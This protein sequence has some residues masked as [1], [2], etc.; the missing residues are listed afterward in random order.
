M[1]FDLQ[2]M[3]LIIELDVNTAKT[4]R[5]A[6]Y[7]GQSLFRSNVLQTHTHR[8]DHSLWATKVVDKKSW[9]DRWVQRLTTARMAEDGRSIWKA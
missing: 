9:L 6:K 1:N 4:S 8:T 2:C 5:R 3:T 7:H